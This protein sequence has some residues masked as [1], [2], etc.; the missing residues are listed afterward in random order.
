MIELRAGIGFL[1][2]MVAYLICIVFA[3]DAV[4]DAALFCSD[5]D[6]I[7]SA[8][9][10]DVSF[11]KAILEKKLCAVMLKFD[12]VHIRISTFCRR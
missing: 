2:S 10:C 3:L 4:S 7:I 5:I 1:H 8:C 11:G 12:A 9:L 6:T